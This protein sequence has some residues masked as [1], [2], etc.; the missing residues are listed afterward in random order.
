MTPET[1]TF[2]VLSGNVVSRAATA[3]EL[4]AELVE[5][6]RAEAD[7]IRE[8]AR[9][10]G[11][12]AGLAAASEESASRVASACETL[13]AGVHDLDRLLEETT[14]ELERQAGE[15]AVAIAERILAVALAV[16]P[17]LIAGVVAGALRANGGRDRI[18][19]EVN[20]DDVALVHDAV[21]ALPAI[22]GRAEVIAQRDIPRGGCVVRSNEGETDGRIAVQLER[23]AELVRVALSRHDASSGR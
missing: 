7:A 10:E 1:F 2:P 15:L 8:R 21:A 14:A 18:T 13:A 11:F 23:A 5:L 20:D 12:A 6:A 16:R 3:A 4:A 19:L 9:A 22:A 17:E